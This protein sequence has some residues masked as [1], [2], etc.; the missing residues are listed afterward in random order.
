MCVRYIVSSGN[1][2]VVSCTY[3]LYR[4]WLQGCCP[5]NPFIVRAVRLYNKRKTQGVVLNERGQTVLLCL[6]QLIHLE[7]RGQILIP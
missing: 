6:P 7:I 1:E 4:Y 2:I 5:V 3:I